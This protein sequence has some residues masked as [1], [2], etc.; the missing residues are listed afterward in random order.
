MHDRIS[1]IHRSND[2]YMAQPRARLV[3]AENVADLWRGCSPVC[4]ARET[5]RR[6]GRI[7]LPCISARSQVLPVIR[8]IISIHVF[9]ALPLQPRIDTVDEIVDAAVVR[10]AAVGVIRDAVK[11]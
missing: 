3:E 4:K 11:G 8:V 6:V 5:R 10:S 9:D 7:E 1:L 2:R